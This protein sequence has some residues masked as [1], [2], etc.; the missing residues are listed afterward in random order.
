MVVLSQTG[1]MDAPRQLFCCFPIIIAMMHLAKNRVVDL[2]LSLLC[3]AGSV[4][5]LGM[6]VAGWPV[7]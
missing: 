4:I 7:V 5:Y 6:Y 3:I 1:V 2:L